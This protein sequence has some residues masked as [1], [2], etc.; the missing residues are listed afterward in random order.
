[1]G[2]LGLAFFAFAYFFSPARRLE[3]PYDADDFLE[4]FFMQMKCTVI[5]VD[6]HAQYSPQSVNVD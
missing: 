4:V 2:S 3:D 1:M 6:G 5:Q